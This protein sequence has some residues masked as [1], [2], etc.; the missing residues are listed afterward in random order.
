MTTGFAKFQL[1]QLKILV[2][3]KYGRDI[4]F[5][6]NLTPLCQSFDRDQRKYSEVVKQAVEERKKK[7]LE[8]DRSTAPPYSPN[9]SMHP[10]QPS[11]GSTLPSAPA[12]PTQLPIPHGVP[13]AI[14][15]DDCAVDQTLQQNVNPIGNTCT[16]AVSQRPSTDN[17]LSPPAN[18][19]QH[20]S[21]PPSS[22]PSP[23]TPT[24]PTSIRTEP[25]AFQP[26]SPGYET[27]NRFSVLDDD[28]DG[29]SVTD[30]SEDMKEQYIKRRKNRR[31]TGK[32]SDKCRQ[33]ESSNCEE[34]KNGDLPPVDIVLNNN[35]DHK[36]DDNN[37][38][39][40]NNDNSTSTSSNNDNNNDN[41]SNNNNNNDNNSNNIEDP[42]AYTP[43]FG[44]DVYH[45]DRNDAHRDSMPIASVEN[46]TNVRSPDATPLT[47]IPIASVDNETPVHD[48]DATPITPI[49][50]PILRM[51]SQ[52]VHWP[53]V[54]NNYPHNRQRE[55]PV[56]CGSDTVKG[57]RYN[58]VA[59]INNS[60]QKVTVDSGA[61]LSV[62][63][64]KLA[65]NLGLK[66]FKV[67]K[68]TGK[69][70]TGP[71]DFEESTCCSL[72]FGIIKVRVMFAVTSHPMYTENLIL[73]G[74]NALKDLNIVADFEAETI[75]IM[76]MYPVKLF[77]NKQS[78]EQ[79]I[80]Q[81]KEEFV[82]LSAVEVIASENIW[83]PAFSETFFDIQMNQY[84][85]TQLQNA[86]SYFTS[87]KCK[88]NGIECP[89]MV[90]ED[91]FP[92][93]H[94]PLRVRLINNDSM[95]R[96]VIK[97][98]V[99]GLIKPLLSKALAK[100]LSHEQLSQIQVLESV[101]GINEIDEEHALNL[102]LG[103]MGYDDNLV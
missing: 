21:S 19:A 80:K 4:D 34:V 32:K 33:C 42:P 84:D 50:R 48:P 76:K 81:I 24:L 13:I 16:S 69:A 83:V 53:N 37:N 92:W 89:D 5:R 65:T 47:P 96:L 26:L 93:D 68:I 52:S 74:S 101:E 98:S 28:N 90:I 56:I 78:I 6:Q 91:T 72:D 11:Q 38:D 35:N 44:G 55:Q 66:I 1:Q 20:A 62:M 103:D 14:G 30:S 49:P 12:Q 85:T 7:N 23:P 9:A 15:E 3:A 60:V 75:Y 31:S 61:F 99:I 86:F 8:S 51:P 45:P 36:D 54:D 102:I 27:R 97:G 59:I 40:D 73:L 63:S 43:A 41:N 46:E 88:L 57:D 17:N 82:C 64:K 18:R 94:E 39:D 71:I 25:V 29:G 77:T 87:E 58:L 10:P 100:K 67:P 22:P 2:K 79:H 70:A 95:D